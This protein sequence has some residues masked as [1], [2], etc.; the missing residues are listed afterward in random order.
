MIIKVNLYQSVIQN[1]KQWVDL[2][3]HVMYCIYLSFVIFCRLTFLEQNSTWGMNVTGIKIG[4]YELYFLVNSFC[5]L[6]KYWV[7]SIAVVLSLLL[8]TLS[9]QNLKPKCWLPEKSIN[10]QA[11]IKLS[12]WYLQSGNIYWNKIW[13]LG[14]TYPQWEC[15]LSRKQHFSRI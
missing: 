7:G 15:E 3:L 8:N 12:C 9:W 13:N 1:L 14:I 2:T 5:S 4:G 6:G 11:I 10:W